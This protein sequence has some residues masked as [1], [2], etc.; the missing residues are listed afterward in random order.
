[1]KKEKG[2]IGCVTCGTS[3]GCFSPLVLLFGIALAVAASS[4]F[5]S[6]YY[7]TEE[8]TWAI[9]VL[10]AIIVPA[11]FVGLLQAA[12]GVWSLFGFF[13]GDVTQDELNLLKP[14]PLVSKDENQ[15]DE[16]E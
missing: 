12:I 8:D 2:L 5:D 13:D 7:W 15:E 3:L 10:V 1:M 11:I 9:I 14:I 4:Y 16:I 6:S